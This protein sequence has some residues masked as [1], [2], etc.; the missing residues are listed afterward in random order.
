MLCN[1][2]KNA[3]LY[4]E[5]ETP[6][7]TIQF[8][9]EDFVITVEDKGL[10]IPEDEM[11]HLFQSFFRAR[12]IV[13]LNIPGNGLGLVIAKRIADLHSGS[14]EIESEENVG[15]KVIMTLPINQ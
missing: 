10:G 1:I 14:I 12:N 13:N 2:L 8:N 6:D 7:C 9:E 3:F 11:S 15:T 4:C 5:K